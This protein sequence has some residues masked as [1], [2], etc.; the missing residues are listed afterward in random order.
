VAVHQSVRHGPNSNGGTT[1]VVFHVRINSSMVEYRL[2]T[3][4][5][6]LLSRLTRKT[7]NNLPFLSIWLHVVVRIS[8]PYFKF[9]SLF[10]I[11]NNCKTTSWKDDPE[12]HTDMPPN[13]TG[14]TSGL[15][16]R[17]DAPIVLWFPLDRAVALDYKQHINKNNPQPKVTFPL[18]HLKPTDLLLFDRNTFLHRSSKPIYPNFSNFRVLINLSTNLDEL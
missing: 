9:A 10:L 7:V 15:D 13:W 11:K 1:K 12:F 3:L 4:P 8:F 5:N 18:L 16:C 17:P 2:A 6:A 14:D